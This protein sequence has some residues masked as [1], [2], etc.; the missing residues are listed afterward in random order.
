MADITYEVVKSDLSLVGVEDYSP[1]D[2][3]LVDKFEINT[4]FNTEDSIE[5]HIYGFNGDRLKSI[6][7][8]TNYKQLFDATSKGSQGPS[9]LYIDPKQDA[10]AYGFTQGD[11]KLLYHFLKVLAPTVFYIDEISKDRTELRVSTTDILPIDI[12]QNLVN[13]LESDAYKL[14]LRLNFTFNELL[15]AVNLRFDQNYVY[16]KLYEPLPNSIAVKSQFYLVEK[17]S[18][19]SAFEVRTSVTP[20]PIKYRYLKGPNFNVDVDYDSG[21]STE[22]LNYNQLFSYPVTSSYHKLLTQA[23]SSGLEISV[24]YTDYADFIHFS[25]AQERLANFKYKLQLV[26]YYESASSALTSTLAGSAPFATIKT[27]TYYDNLVKGVISKF[28]GY[29]KYLYFE[30][31][32]FAW[33]KQNSSPTYINQSY[34]SI[35]STT[36]YNRQLATASLYDEL[37]ESNLEY[38]IPEFIRQDTLNAPYSLFINMIGQHFDNIWL[39]TKAITD[40]Y[41]ADN[42]L[43]YGVSK[44]LVTDI[45]KS[46]GVRLYNS[47]FSVAN[48]SSLILGEWYDSGSEQIS[49]FVT[50]SNNPTPDQDILQETYKRIYHNLPYLIKTKGT[51][52][53]LR[54][55][56]N[57]FGIPSGSL[58]IFTYGGIQRPGNTP[59][60]ASTI[61]TSNKIRLANTGSNIPGNTLSQYVSTVKQDNKFTQDQ[62]VIEVGFSPTYNIDNYIQS[63]ITSSFNIDQYIGDPRY[64]Y[65]SNYENTT[66]GNLYRVA[67]TLLS[68]SNTYD[69]FDFIRLIKFFD[70][71]LF[72]MVKDFTPARDISTSGVIIK[73]HILNRNKVKSAQ[74]TWSRPE[75]TASIDTAFTTGSAAGIIN[76]YSTTYTERVSGLLGF[77]NQPHTAGEEKFTGELGGSVVTVY[78]GSLNNSNVFKQFDATPLTYDFIEYLQGD[79]PTVTETDFLTLPVSTGKMYTFRA[80]QDK[81]GYHYLKYILFRNTSK[82]G[83]DVKEAVRVLDN[84]YINGTKYIFENKNVQT[85]TTLLTFKDPGGGFFANPAAFPTSQVT[86]D[87]IFTPFFRSRFDNSDYNA[88]FNNAVIVDTATSVQKV[89]YSDNPLV[90]VNLAALR[91]NTAQKADVQEYV[92]NSAGFVSSRYTGQQLFASEINKYTAGDRSY[93]RVPVIEHTT[94]F[95]CIFDYISGFSPEHNQANAVIISYIVDEQG[96]LITPDSNL[97]L[98][99]LQQGFPANS[100]FEI[101][102]QS[103]NTGG[104]EASLLGTHEVLK[105]ASRIEP[106]VYSYTAATYLSPVF[107]AGNKLQFETDPNL[108]TYDTKAS[109]T[110]QTIS[111]LSIGAKTVLQFSNE[112][113]DDA[114]YFSNPVYTFSADTEQPVRFSG[115]FKIEGDGKPNPFGGD[116]GVIN[117]KFEL[118]TDGGTFAPAYTS[119]IG[120]KQISFGNYL[121]K[122]FTVSTGYSNRN[123][124]EAV[125]AVVEIVDTTYDLVFTNSLLNVISLESGSSY[126]TTGSAGYFFTTGSSSPVT[127]LTGSTD[128]SAKYNYY[129]SGIS[130]SAPEGFNS[131]NLPFTVE[132]GDEIK[133]D[134]NENKSF[135]VTKVITP[136][137]NS[138]NKLY[139]TLSGG[140]TKT[141]NKDFFAIRRYVDTSSML[142]MKI[143]KVVGSG[144]KSG[145]LYPKYPSPALKANYEKI[146]SDLKT[147][148]II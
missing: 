90:P 92:H 22:Y 98:P 52:R 38:S 85:S 89:D 147:K 138:L 133:F 44:D 123:S 2:L 117:V 33:P 43:N 125:R 73:P 15:I 26:Q 102:I 32:A 67:E 134:N 41:N 40:K 81:G 21:T 116:P 28:D 69:V 80:Y 148:G 74:A 63:N 119:V 14:D 68:G 6:Y 132:V 87:V 29:E 47:N 35:E 93:G 30:S 64:L 114:N 25:S 11:V 49:T 1:T 8:Y 46:F 88:L 7:D 82:N 129:F 75:Y 60:Y 103:V 55:L 71:Q 131:V 141:M 97:A 110:N 20:D 146:I 5:L 24:D 65:T 120:S 118:T 17:T 34:D 51:E 99:I 91:N 12:L 61:P 18:D 83:V 58:E 45:L 27:S 109:N 79:S 77:I 78:S 140:M 19:S 31:G 23:S 57:C 113:K 101:S 106:I 72:K 3:T 62:H 139:I 48:L 16:F 126:V 105:P 96:N 100:E 112:L 108:T 54:A 137:E 70:N 130:G 135:L 124:G 94:P 86:V 104:D 95:F 142:L 56:I 107:S 121:P 59:Y 122:T 13:R 9:S 145:V 136:E 143:D 36:W 53:G 4:N 10:I 115:T 39:Y 42:R 128:L 37:N 127:V 76:E 66:N 84:L 111:N 50:A 144:G